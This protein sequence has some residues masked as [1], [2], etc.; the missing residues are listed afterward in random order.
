V[1]CIRSTWQIIYGWKIHTSTTLAMWIRILS[2]KLVSYHILSMSSS[3]LSVQK[4][5]QISKKYF[6]PQIV[7]CYDRV[8]DFRRYKLLRNLIIWNEDVI[9]YS[10]AIPSSNNSLLYSI[11]HYYYYN[12]NIIYIFWTYFDII[13]NYI[14][15]RKP[16]YKRYVYWNVND[17][18]CIQA[19]VK[20]FLHLIADYNVII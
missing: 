8:Q 2:G 20:P 9:R 10:V 16:A 15:S 4:Y 11:N 14:L 12:M 7:R 6:V 13:L 5:L 18:G 19:M 3:I 1:H 17:V